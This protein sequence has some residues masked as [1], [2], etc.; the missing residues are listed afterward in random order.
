MVAQTEAASLN[1]D[2]LKNGGRGS[3]GETLISP[4]CMVVVLERWNVDAVKEA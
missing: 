3:E 4:E 2:G 1:D